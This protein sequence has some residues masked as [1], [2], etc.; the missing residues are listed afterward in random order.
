MVHLGVEGEQGDPCD[1]G[2]SHKPDDSGD[3]ITDGCIMELIEEVMEENVVWEV[4]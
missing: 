1:P 2:D 4:M 3:A